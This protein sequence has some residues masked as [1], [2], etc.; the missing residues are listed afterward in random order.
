MQVIENGVI[1]SVE[2]LMTAKAI[3]CFGSAVLNRA[4]RIPV[5]AINTV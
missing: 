4:F 3:A 5:L 1:L 2:T